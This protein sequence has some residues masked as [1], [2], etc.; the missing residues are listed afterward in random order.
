MATASE[1]QSFVEDTYSTERAHGFLCLE[2]MRSSTTFF[3][4]QR[5]DAAGQPGE[6]EGCPP[7]LVAEIY[8]WLDVYAKEGKLIF[9]SNLGEADH[10]MLAG[11]LARLLPPKDSMGPSVDLHVDE[12]RYPSG[13]VHKHFTYYT[14][15]PSGVKV[16]HG[17]HREYTEAGTLTEIEFRHGAPIGQ[18]RVFNE[19]GQ[20]VA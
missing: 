7:W 14:L 10:S 15:A 13:R 19:S 1:I 16:L 5:I 6:L 4:A 2:A 11:R 3:A 20:E 12:L 8:Q 17:L 18:P 9:G